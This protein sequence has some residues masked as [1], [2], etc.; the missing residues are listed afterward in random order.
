MLGGTIQS[1]H[2]V[3]ASIEHQTVE[4]ISSCTMGTSHK[5]VETKKIKENQALSMKK[6]ENKKKTKINDINL[7]T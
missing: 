3:L 6:N 7:I 5:F 2:T 1:Q 4:T